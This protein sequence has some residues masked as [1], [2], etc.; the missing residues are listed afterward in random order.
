MAETPVQLPLALAHDPHYGRDSFVVAPSN[1]AALTLIERWPDWPAPVVL[2]TGPPGAGKTHLAHIWAE[3]AGAAMLPAAALADPPPPLA[4]GGGLVVED[5]DMQA[6]PERALFHLIN[7]A[8]EAGAS[9]LV[10]SRAPLADWRLGV[11]DLHSRLRLAAPA[12]L[13][14]PDETLLRQVL[15]KLFADRQLIVD[16]VVVDYLL[17]RME[18]SLSVAAELV[19]ALDGAALAEGRSITRPLAAEILA[20]FDARLHF[21]NGNIL[22]S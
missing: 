7:V 5:V 22:S 1:R 16:K 2:L 4:P 20:T 10:T 21:R 19:A 9:L 12:V 15:V 11:P 18:R 14:A 13:D 17:V 6:V 8:K 3:A